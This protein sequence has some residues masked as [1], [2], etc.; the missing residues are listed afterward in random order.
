[1]NLMSDLSGRKYWSSAW[2]FFHRRDLCDML[3]V[4]TLQC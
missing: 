1:V 4:C 2:E 3:K